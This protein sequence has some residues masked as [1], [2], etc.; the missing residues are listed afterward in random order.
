MQSALFLGS[1]SRPNRVN[2]A[3]KVINLYRSMN[4][5][6]IVKVL[7]VED[8][9]D[10]YLIARELL[11]EIGSTQYELEW[12]STYEEALEA[13]ESD[14]HDV[15][16]V[17]FYLG[18]HTGLEI[19][20]AAL[21]KSCQTPIIMLTGL[22]DREVDSQAIQAGASDYLVKSQLN[23]QLL[24]RSIRHSIDRKRVEEALKESEARFRDLAK[25]EALLNRL[26]KQ[27]RNSL[28]LPAILDAAVSEICTLLEIDRCRFIWYKKSDKNPTFELVCQAS[29]SATTRRTAYTDA[30]EM[31]ALGKIIL[32]LNALEE[33]SVFCINPNSEMRDLMGV[34]GFAFMMLIPIRTR[35]GKTGI[36]VCERWLPF[37]SISRYDWDGDR[38]E[39]LLAVADQIAIAID[40]AELYERTRVAKEQSDRLLL[41]VLPHTI[42]EHL[43]N[44]NEIIADSFEEVT[45]LFADIVNFTELSSR[46]PAQKMVQLLNLI[47]STFDRLAD[48]HNLEK[49][50]T[51]G[52]A[53][54]VVGG[55][56]L[57]KP[58]H[59]EAIAN[60]ALEMQQEINNFYQD[61]GKPF[62]LRIGINTGPAVA[63]VIGTKKF[64]YDLWG[65]TVNVASR[66]ESQGEAGRIQV[67]AATYERLNS[68][69]VFE[70]RGAIAVKGK[71]E[72]ITY[73]LTGFK[74]L[75]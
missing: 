40:Q 48:K 61:D 69:Y 30:E 38:V 68:Q 64:I 26:A 43:K 45:V 19:L 28:E 65:D 74:V 52:D 47:F 51:I 55:V 5:G 22:G 54:M 56:P 29:K 53:Y 66:M 6:S 16:L 31:E 18:R 60:M 1:E 72:M 11:T 50:K 67:T 24:E 46:I 49:I 23:P 9:E 35:V 71:G 13:I 63:G 12:V 33:S 70:K 8:D 10:D 4:S 3:P 59:A 32:Q 20:Q 75:Y 62:S 7:L 58:D 41:N 27:I 2:I 37:P 17:D 39:L 57:P 42:A 25:R 15:I 21:E 34:F 36:L 44:R 73:W 14:R